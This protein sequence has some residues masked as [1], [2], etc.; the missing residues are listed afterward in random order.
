M[1]LQKTK[2]LKVLKTVKFTTHMGRVL[3]KDLFCTYSNA[4]KVFIIRHVNFD[5][6]PMAR[7]DIK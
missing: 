2:I 3:A 7:N 1:T 5:F 6:I 4:V